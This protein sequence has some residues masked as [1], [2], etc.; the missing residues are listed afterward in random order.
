MDKAG[1]YHPLNDQ[2]QVVSPDGATVREVCHPANTG[3]PLNCSLALAVL[4]RGER[5]KNHRLQNGHEVYHIISGSGILFIDGKPVVMH[6]GDCAIVE[7]GRCQ[8]IQ[9]TGVGELHFYCLVSPP[10]QKSE[11]LPCP[12]R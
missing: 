6:T 2:P 4:P 12:E 5:T 1:I 9:N 8:Y 11:D 10:W 3:W 7:A